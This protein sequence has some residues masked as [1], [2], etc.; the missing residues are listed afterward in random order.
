V[1]RSAHGWQDAK[2]GLFRVKKRGY[3]PAQAMI[4]FAIVALIGMGLCGLF[5]APRIME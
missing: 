4:A 1:P 5:I 3:M 2:I